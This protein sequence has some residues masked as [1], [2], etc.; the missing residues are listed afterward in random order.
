MLRY[1]F[2]EEELPR[3]VHDDEIAAIE[4]LG[5]QFVFRTRV[6]LDISLADLREQFDAVLLTTGDRQTAGE[7]DNSVLTGSHGF[8]A[9]RTSFTTSLPGVFAA[10]AAVG[11]LHHTVRAVADGH[12]AGLAI[13][14]F[15][16]ATRAA[17][18]LNVHAAQMDRDELA[19]RVAAASPQPRVTPR[20]G[21]QEGFTPEEAQREAER[22]LGCACAGAADCKLRSLA[23]RCGAD[24]NRFRGERRA[25]ARDESHPEVLFEAGKCI[26]CGICVRIA[27]G[28]G[29]SF[30]GHGSQIT[31]GGPF[32]AGIRESL[33]DAARACAAA[34]PTGALTL[35]SDECD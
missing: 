18:K 9:D 17:P 20:Q 22:C 10:G 26:A 13:A 23:A 11:P 35:R 21:R 31:V 2:S 4:H 24:P 30:H 8:L 6:G 1:H 7:F 34:C 32:G 28:T 19:A 29:Q 25:Y 16:D 12:A 33:G 27:A 5:V 3:D 15:L 14:H